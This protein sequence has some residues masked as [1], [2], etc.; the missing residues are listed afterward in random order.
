VAD[1]V[2]KQ[3]MDAVIAALNAVDAGA[4]YVS[5]IAHVS[6][7]L[8]KSIEQIDKSKLPACFPIDADETRRSRTIGSGTDDMESE[9]VVICTCVVWDQN[10]ST[11]QA[12]TDLMRDVEKTLLNDTSLAALIEWIEPGRITTDKGQIPNYSVWDQEF[13]IQYV[14]SSADGG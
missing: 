12:R 14:Y 3:I 1:S 7:S 11:R 9:L 13:T 10:D 6:E 2:R 4:T 5:T 8:P